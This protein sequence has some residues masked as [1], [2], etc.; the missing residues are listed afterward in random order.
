MSCEVAATGFATS[1][2]AAV[3]DEGVRIRIGK[4]LGVRGY[5]GL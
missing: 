3:S 1:F 2:N 4:V 5:S